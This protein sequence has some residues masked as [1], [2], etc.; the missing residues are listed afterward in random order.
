MI[1]DAFLNLGIFVANLIISLFPVGGGLPVEAHT[2]ALTIST[3]M[4]L[5]N[6]IIPISTLAL[7]VAFVYTVELSIFSFKTIRMFLSHVPLVGG[8]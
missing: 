5:I 6:L 8:K 4:G 2:T 1:T 3:Y 7:G